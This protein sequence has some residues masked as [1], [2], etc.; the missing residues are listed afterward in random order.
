GSVVQLAN[1]AGSVTDT[2]LYDSFGNPLLTGQTT[3][4]P[5]RYVG[6]QG[7][8]YDLDL[9]GYYLRARFYDPG[10]GRFLSRDPAGFEGRDFNFYRYVLS[11]PSNFTDP[12]GLGCS[13]WT[14]VWRPCGPGDFA[15]CANF[16]R[17]RN[18]PKFKVSRCETWTRVCSYSILGCHIYTV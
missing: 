17:V 15:E 18:F 3:V 7:Y 9:V 8:Q 13:P 1:S 5:Y 4:N 12:P 6:Q 14:K 10:T 2:Y 11:N 16:C